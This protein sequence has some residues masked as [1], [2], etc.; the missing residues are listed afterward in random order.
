MNWIIMMFV[1]W[2]A[3]ERS[4]YLSIYKFCMYTLVWETDSKNLISV[5]NSRPTF[6]RA[7]YILFKMNN[8][9]CTS[10]DICIENSFMNAS[11][12]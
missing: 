8:E 11:A 2:K 7:L 6:Q 9:W 3:N 10:K 1:Y 4:I 5:P 12:L